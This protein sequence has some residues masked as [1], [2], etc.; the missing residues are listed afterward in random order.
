MY[1][2]RLCIL[3]LH[4]FGKE[5]SL[6]FFFQMPNDLAKENFDYPEEYMHVCAS[7]STWSGVWW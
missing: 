2:N 3:A 5:V 1:G 6:C 4:L 7:C